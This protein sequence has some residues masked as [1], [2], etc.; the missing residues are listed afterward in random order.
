MDGS[1]GDA[2]TAAEVASALGGPANVVSLVHCATRLRVSVRDSGRVDLGAVSG[3]PGIIGVATLGDQ[4]QIVVGP[5][6]VERAHAALALALHVPI[7]E[8]EAGGAGDSGPDAAPAESPHRRPIVRPLYVLMDIV[9]PLLPTFVAAGMLLALHNILSAPGVFGQG[10]VAATV[11][12]LDGLSALIGILGIG[13]FTLLPVFVGYSAAARFGGSPFLGAAM[14][15]ALVAAP[16]VVDA[17]S[18]PALHVGGGGSWTI[19]GVDVLGIDYRGTV[20]PIV[21]IAY[22]LTLIERGLGTVLRGAARFLLVPML[23]L[24]L[25][26]VL[27]FLVVGPVLRFAGDG[28]ARLIALVYEQSGLLGGV[29]F[30]ALYPLLV[31]TGTH[32]SLVSL[33]LGLLATGG[34]FIFPAAGAANLA[35]AGACFAVAVL[36]GRRTRLRAL[37][38]GAGLPACVGIAEPAIFGINLR[39]RFPFIAAVI[40]SSIGG[41][42]LAAFNVQAVTLGAAGVVGV[43]SIAPGSGL[44]YLAAIG[45]SGMIAFLVTLVWGRS[46]RAR[47]LVEDAVHT[48]PA[49]GARPGGL[50]TLDS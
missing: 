2:R 38:A 45:A 22:L 34:S 14:G 44:E 40:A 33:E 42:V 50:G 17:G 31:L 3:L 16:F 18:F 7:K 43:A 26:G 30:G 23:T 11:P 29:V 27:A 10:S 24:L 12:W 1:A 46:G 28:F 25:T 37:A 8:S 36:A 39:L 41:G 49:D 32:Q 6:A 48:V 21:A 4:I 19:A 13:V 20:I 35:Q 9:A 15:A 47:A 5:Q